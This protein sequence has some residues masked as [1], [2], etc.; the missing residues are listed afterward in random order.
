MTNIIVLAL[1]NCM[2]TAVAGPLEILTIANR[3]ND[4]GQS[5][6]YSNF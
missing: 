6:V 4:E 5:A 2:A 1:D 3:I